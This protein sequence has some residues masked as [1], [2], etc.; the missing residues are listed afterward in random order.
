MNYFFKPF[1]LRII[2]PVFMVVCLLSACK[3]IDVFE[4][5]TP[6]PNMHWQN[7]FNALGSFKITDTTSFYNIFIVLRHTD[8]YVYNN[9]WLNIG[10]Q[11][12]EDSAIQYQ[13]INISLGTDANGWE[14]VG[15]ND[16]WEIRKLISGRPKKFIKPGYYTFN[17][18]QLMR[19]NPLEYIMSVGLRVEKVK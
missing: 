6:I 17:I 18:T 12:P 3:E 5:N 4:K 19:D 1:L 9:I 8:K 7:N 15:M 11:A 16:I 2:L 10:L 14:G 13:K